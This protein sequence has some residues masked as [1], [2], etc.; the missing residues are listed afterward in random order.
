[1]I[2]LNR[3]EIAAF[4]GDNDRL[5]TI[6]DDDPYE[7]FEM[8]DEDSEGGQG[9]WDGMHSSSGSDPSEGSPKKAKGAK[10]EEDLLGLDVS[11]IS[12]T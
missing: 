10:K 5:E 2:D 4:G 3:I 8:E 11:N 12:T 6:D 7:D 1:M 9:Q